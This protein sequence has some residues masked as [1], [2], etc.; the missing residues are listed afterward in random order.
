MGM[1]FERIR[2]DYRQK[3][4]NSSVNAISKTKRGEETDIQQNDE[5]KGWIKIQPFKLLVPARGVEP[6]T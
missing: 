3:T 6:L 5:K 1:A 2:T 4:H